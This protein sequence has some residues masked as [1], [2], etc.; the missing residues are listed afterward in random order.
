MLNSF[1]MLRS[2]RPA[3]FT[4]ILISLI[5]I[6]LGTFFELI[7]FSLDSLFNEHNQLGLIDTDLD[8]VFD[9]IGSFL[10]GG[11]LLAKDVYL[12]TQREKI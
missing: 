3:V 9:C 8:L 12:N 2:S 10:A 7:E 4:F 11:F 1:I 6:S 5:G